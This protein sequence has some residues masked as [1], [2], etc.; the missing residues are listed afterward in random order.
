MFLFDCVYISVH[1]FVLIRVA[2]FTLAD[3]Q[4][5][6]NFN[7]W[8]V[9][10]LSLSVFFDAMIPNCQQFLMSGPSPAPKLEVMFFSNFFGMLIILVTL[11]VGGEGAVAIAYCRDHPD[12][13]PILTLF[14]ACT[15][16]GTSFY[17][18]AVRRFGAVNAITIT[19][20][21]KILTLML[22]FV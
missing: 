13:V 22:S 16:M 15:Y 2:V 4:V 9:I 8:G 14:G 12:V 11:I 1:L 19:T 18:T 7:M 21:R 6:P 5:S 3:A 20:L 10:L 17:V